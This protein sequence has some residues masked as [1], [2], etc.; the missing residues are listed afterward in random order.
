MEVTLQARQILSDFGEMEESCLLRCPLYLLKEKR[1]STYVRSTFLATWA[2]VATQELLLPPCHLGCLAGP[3]NYLHTQLNG[4]M[5]TN[6]CR[7]TRN[8]GIR[9]YPV[10]QIPSLMLR[11]GLD[12][13]LGMAWAVEYGLG[14]WRTQVVFCYLVALLPLPLFFRFVVLV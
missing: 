1:T 4:T 11:I 3:F 6:R 7:H 5:S 13:C 9:L 8:Q 12:A 14:T 2:H 10:R